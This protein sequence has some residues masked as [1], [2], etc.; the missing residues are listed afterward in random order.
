[1]SLQISNKSCTNM[2]GTS[3]DLIYRSIIECTVIASNRPGSFRVN[4]ALANK[5]FLELFYQ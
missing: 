2:T 3:C 4:K 5:Y 1:M